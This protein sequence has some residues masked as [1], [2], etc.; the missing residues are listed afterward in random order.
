[1]LKMF[2]FIVLFVILFE[3]KNDEAQF[4]N[5]VEHLMINTREAC[6]IEF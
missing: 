1:M 3:K 2:V 5:N 4:V 6:F